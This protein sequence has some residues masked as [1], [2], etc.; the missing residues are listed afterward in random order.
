MLVRQ[1]TVSTSKISITELRRRVA[2]E[3]VLV[4]VLKQVS[5]LKRKSHTFLKLTEK[6]RGKRKIGQGWYKHLCETMRSREVINKVSK[7]INCNVLTNI[8]LPKASK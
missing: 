7:V 2:A 1:L 5:V 3:L 8:I 6:I 4:L